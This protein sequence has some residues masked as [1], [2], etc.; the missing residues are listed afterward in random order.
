MAELR[1]RSGRAIVSGGGPGRT[2]GT[3]VALGRGVEPGLAGTA[4]VAWTW[5]QGQLWVGSSE[6][7]VAEE[8]A[9]PEPGGREGRWCAAQGA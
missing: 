7:E 4:W 5:R 2:S 6:P 3:L 9:S 1:R 8:E